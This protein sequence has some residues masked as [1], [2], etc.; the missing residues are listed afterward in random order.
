MQL[1]ILTSFPPQTLQKIPHCNLATGSKWSLNWYQDLLENCFFALESRCSP[2]KPSFT[3]TTDRI[4]DFKVFHFAGSFVVVRYRVGWRG[5]FVMALIELFSVFLLSEFS[6][7]HCIVVVV[8][9]KPILVFSTE[10]VGANTFSSAAGS[11]IQHPLEFESKSFLGSSGL[12]LSPPM[13]RGNFANLHTCS[14]PQITL[15]Y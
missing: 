6:S 13:K 9:T 1:K 7:P 8:L 4:P 14:K 11:T 15:H 3:I 5:D 10:T 2:K 12:H